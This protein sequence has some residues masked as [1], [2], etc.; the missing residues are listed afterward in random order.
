M[1]GLQNVAGI[2][3]I[4]QALGFVAVLFFLL[5]RFKRQYPLI[6]VLH[7]FGNR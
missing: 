3:S 4:V 7:L 5:V 6:I 2:A 1:K